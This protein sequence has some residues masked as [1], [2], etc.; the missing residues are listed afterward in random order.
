MDKHVFVGGG[1]MLILGAILVLFVYGDVSACGSF[2]GLFAQ[3]FDPSVAAQC[4]LDAL[5]LDV[6]VILGLIGLIS[7]IGGAALSPETPEEMEGTPTLP[8]LPTYAPGQV[9]T[10]VRPASPPI[11]PPGMDGFCPAC[12]RANPQS[13]AFC[14]RCGKPL[15]WLPSYLPSQ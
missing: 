5:A 13:S 6:G 10:S 8:A 1:V 12:G 4:R 9:Q 11:A 3:A 2:F 7:L 15:P 14:I